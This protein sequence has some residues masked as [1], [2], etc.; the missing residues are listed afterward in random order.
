M[1][2][3]SFHY[4]VAIN[5]YF[6][7]ESMFHIKPDASKLALIYFCNVLK[8]NGIEFIDCQVPSAH[9][10][11]MGAKIYEKK[12]FIPMIQKASG[13]LEIKADVIK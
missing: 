5:K 9:L 2:L 8:D 3:I 12:D 11:R 4:G 7:G 1:D 10:Q 13:V 6:S